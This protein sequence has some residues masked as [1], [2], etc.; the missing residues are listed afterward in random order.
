[1]HIEENLISDL[2]VIDSDDDSEKFIVTDN[3]NGEVGDVI[4]KTYAGKLLVQWR[5]AIKSDIHEE[6]ELVLLSSPNIT[7]MEKGD[8]KGLVKNPFGLFGKKKAFDVDLRTEDEDYVSVTIKA[9]NE[10]SAKRLLKKYYG[11]NIKIDSFEERI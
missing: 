3:E 2:T 6:F 11:R 10:T 8:D 4:A 7:F 1:M 5:D 9:A